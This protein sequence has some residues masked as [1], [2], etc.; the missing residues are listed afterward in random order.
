M[1]AIDSGSDQVTHGAAFFIR[2][3]VS[4]RVTMLCLLLVAR[5]CYFVVEHPSQTMLARHPRWEHFMNSQVYVPDLQK[6][7]PFESAKLE[8]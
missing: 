6:P 4:C 8:Q 5:H 3:L 1:L 7:I 2:M